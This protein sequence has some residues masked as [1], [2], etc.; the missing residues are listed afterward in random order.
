M[1]VFVPE[2]VLT[3][4]PAQTFEHIRRLLADAG[5]E[6]D[7][8]YARWWAADALTLMGRY[9]EAV[10]MYPPPNLER[11]SFQTERLLSL[12]V[13]AGLPYT[14]TDALALLGPRITT[15]GRAHI[16]HVRRAAGLLVADM[17]EDDRVGRLRVWSGTSPKRPYSVYVGSAAGYHASKGIDLTHYEFSK[18][19]HFVDYCRTLARKAEN[20]VR[21]DAGLPRV[22]EG[23]LSET[24]LFY[25]LRDAFPEQTVEQH[26]SPEWLG[27]QHLDVYLPEIAVGVEFQ[28]AQHD[29]PVDFF[30]GPEAY[31]AVQKRDA[32]KLRLCKRHGVELVYARPG[33]DLDAVVAEIRLRAYS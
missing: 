17:D 14:A 19:S 25:E 12:K 21:E 28:G 24:R 15:Y 6:D 7:T 1:T 8:W 4:R 16:D 2:D 30:G 11:A 23:W 31:E 18:A 20:M 5:P 29:G 22:G 32:R 10:E 26:A 3:L 9:R 13:A 27:R 33:Y